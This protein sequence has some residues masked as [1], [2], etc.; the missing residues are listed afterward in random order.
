VSPTSSPI[1]YLYTH[2]IIGKGSGLPVAYATLRLVWRWLFEKV[3][4]VGGRCCRATEQ[5]VCDGDYGSLTYAHAD[6]PS[7]GRSMD[8][9]LT[10]AVFAQP[11]AVRNLARWLEP[12]GWHLE[13]TRSQCVSE[14]GGTPSYWV[15]FAQ[16]Y[17]PRV[18]EA[19]LMD[20]A[21]VSSWW[22]AQEQ[23]IESRCFFAACN[24]YTF[25]ARRQH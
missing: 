18:V 12:S 20:E 1:F 11:N 17:M 8:G 21:T 22:A 2:S 25:L 6:D 3:I 10:S 9:A 14:V 4:R 23:A 7:L 5:V 24:Y 15:S 13:Q 19:G 16:A